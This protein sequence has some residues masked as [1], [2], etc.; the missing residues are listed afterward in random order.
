[1]PNYVGNSPSM[2]LSSGPRGKNEE[3][4]WAQL[5]D[6]QAENARL[7][8]LARDQPEAR[9]AAP[10]GDVHEAV[11]RARAEFSGTLL[12]ASDLTV[13]TREDGAFWYAVLGALNDLCQKD[14]AGELTGGHTQIDTLLPDLLDRRGGARKRPKHADT[15]IEKVDPRTN[16][17]VHLRWRLH[18]RSGA[19]G[20]SESI[21]W[22]PAAHG[23]TKIFLVGWL[24]NHPD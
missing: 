10:T 1:M 8:S 24:G 20:E 2:T 16:A 21:Y 12:F 6:L 5:R 17:R 19:P 11:S 15:G 14:Q 22:E 9:L 4:A 3:A 7:R 18:L 23:G 13:D